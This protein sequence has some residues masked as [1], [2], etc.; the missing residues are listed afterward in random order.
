MAGKTR[1]VVL[2]NRAID[3]KLRG[4]DLVRLRVPDVPHGAH[5]LS[6]A[7]IV[8][9]KTQRPVRFEV[10]EQTRETVAAWVAEAKL[11]A[12][13]YLYP[14]AAAWVSASLH[15]PVCPHRQTVD[16]VGRR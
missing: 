11:S 5:G 9:Q 15:S 7:T 14:E 13:D 16:P 4:C 10:T 12:G 8:E 1:E 3:S 6:R 2:F